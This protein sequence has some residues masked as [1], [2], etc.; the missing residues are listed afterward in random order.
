[1]PAVGAQSDDH[2]SAVHKRCRN[3]ALRNSGY[4]LIYPEYR[5]GYRALLDLL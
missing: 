5:S 1:L 4:D 3:T 2:R